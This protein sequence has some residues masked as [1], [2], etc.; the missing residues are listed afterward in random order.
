MASNKPLSILII[1][2]SAI[3][4]VVHTLPLLEVLRSNFA[5]ARIDWL[6]EEDARQIIENHK[7]IDQIIVSRRKSWL[8][9]LARVGE[10]PGLVKEIAGFLGELRSKE[11]DIVIDLQGLFKSGILTGLSRGKRKIGFTGGREGSVLFLT[12]RPFRV[13]YNRHA[14]DRYLETATYLDIHKTPWNGGIPITEEAKRAVDA[15]LQDVGLQEKKLIAVNPIAKW[16]TK[17]WEPGKFSLLADRLAGQ[18]SF[19]ILFTGSGADRP[20]I[21]GIISNMKNPAANLAGR[22]GLKELA[23]LYSRCRLVVS[24]DTGPMHIAA[25][26]RTPVVA[27]FG[28]TA[29]WRTGPY[30]KGNR[31]VRSGVG[32]SPCFQKVCDHRT[33]MREITVEKVFKSVKK[34]LA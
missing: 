18:L 3:G 11:Y 14:I 29:P 7:D 23:Y 9:R 27:I 32:C 8:Q 22:T 5:H 30:G 34:S 28:P 25:A 31:V 15:F 17:L 16:E 2:L 26:M 10:V 33:C 6:V 4:D 19:S 12:E 1:K 21:D 24:T 20:Q 13:D